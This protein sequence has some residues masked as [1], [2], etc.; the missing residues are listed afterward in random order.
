MAG[1]PTVC[2]QWR[3]RDRLPRSSSRLTPSARPYGRQLGRTVAVHT[4][5]CD[6]SLWLPI[7]IEPSAAPQAAGGVSVRLTGGTYG[8]TVRVYLISLS[9]PHSELATKVDA[10]I[11]R[12]FDTYPRR[13][14]SAWLV[15][16]PDNVT[17]GD[18]RGKYR[19]A[20]VALEL[21]ESPKDCR[22][23]H[24]EPG[25]PGHENRASSGLQPDVWTADPDSILSRLQRICERTS[26]SGH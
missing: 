8:G 19:E 3:P 13:A 16:V 15:V 7:T 12:T 9:I 23:V 2:A 20:V 14:T 21:P 11:R 10:A 24:L 5:V 6:S 1:I 22:V 17:A 18:V 25:H 4:P 26:A